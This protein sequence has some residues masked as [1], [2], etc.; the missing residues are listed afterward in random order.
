M[1]LKQFIYR[2]ITLTVANSNIRGS[3]IT[4]ENETQLSG[5]DILRDNQRGRTA[6]VNEATVYYRLEKKP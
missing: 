3:K 6:T 2:F 5:G 4:R 1:I